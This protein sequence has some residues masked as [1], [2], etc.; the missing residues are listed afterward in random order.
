MTRPNILL[1]TS[2]Q[3]HWS[4]LGSQTPGLRT[5]HLD[6]LAAAGT[7][8]DRA[9]C[10]NPTCTPTRASIITGLYPSQHGAWTLGTKLLE[11]VPVVG[12]DFQRGGYR[13]ALVGKAHFQPL[14]GTPA[15]PSLEA[16]PVLQ[17]LAWWRGFHGPFYGFEHVELA[18][19]HG[20]EAHVGQHYALWMEAQGATDWRR[21]FRPPTGSRR[22]G[23]GVWEIPEALHVNTWIAERTEAL[24]AQYA[25]RQEPFFL[26][27][28]FFDPHPPYLVPDPWASMYDPEALPVPAPMT[29]EEL[30]TCSPLVR[31]ALTRDAD[32][33]EFRE[34]GFSLHGCHYHQYDPPAQVRRQTA[35]YWGMMSFLDA[36]VGRILAGL[37]R[38]GLAQDTLVVFT[39]DHGHL[40]GQHGLHAKG[41]FH[42]EDLIRIP[43]LARHP[44]RIPAARRA[45][46]LIS[47][48]DLAP[49][50]L[51]WCGLPVPLRMTGIDQGPVLRGE[52]PPARDHVLVEFRH[53]PTTVFLKTFVDARYKITVHYGRPYGELFDL[54]E[55]PGETRN[56]WDAPA[57]QGLKHRLLERFLHAE[58][59]KESLPMPRVAHA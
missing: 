23:E 16:Y 19:M 30:A 20:D 45:T 42:Y 10:P 40:Y 22:G 17:D 36:A 5:P 4:L 26:W 12:D 6:A 33:D 56:L 11:E 55:D 21:W 15:Y 3:Q 44:G 29:P 48:V 14:A 43:F 35:L 50:F 54:A 37:E 46:D 9:Y 25:A 51:A 53:E 31:R 47:T 59:R 49:T 13:T 7:R 18:R 34:S 1:I 52:A 57:V 24:L 38:L 2:D 32:W 28:S 39:T 41:P 27:S 8:F 58:W